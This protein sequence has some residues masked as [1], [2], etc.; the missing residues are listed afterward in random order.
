VRTTRAIVD[1]IV[2]P[3]LDEFIHRRR[4]ESLSWAIAALL[5]GNRLSLTGL[6]RG[7]RSNVA[8]KHEVK[9]ADRL[10]GNAGL[11]EDQHIVFCW[12]ARLLME[13]TDEVVVAVDWTPV[14]PPTHNALYAAVVHSG[15][16]LPILFE[17]HGG[18]MK[19]STAIEGA[20]LARLRTVVPKGLKVIIIA[21]AGFRGPFFAAGDALGF[22]VVARLQGNVCVGAPGATKTVGALSRAATHSIDD[23]GVT[24]VNKVESYKARVVRAPKRKPRLVRTKSRRPERG[25]ETQA[26]KRHGSAWLLATNITDKSAAEIHHIY[27]QRMQIE[28]VFRDH[29]NTRFGWS[30][31]HA[32]FASSDDTKR[33][34]RMSNLLL[35]A[36]MATVIAQLI[37]RLAESM[38]WHRRFQANTV[39][40]RVLALT[41]LASAVLR[42]SHR[43][44]ILR[45]RLRHALA[46]V[47]RDIAMVSTRQEK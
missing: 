40:R 31:R 10:V 46:L 2:V 36:A 22:S 23:F 26:R 30:L 33:R 39:R 8:T 34:I 29:K 25:R 1:D 47:Q 24:R 28:E 43:H 32:R 21:D 12:L 16:A 14:N 35:I 3:G 13:G 45:G 6:G 9:R 15:R 38:D 20:F 18:E 41:S 42:S 5:D 4:V 44:E 27:M 37:G 19:N 7:S 17:V 11:F